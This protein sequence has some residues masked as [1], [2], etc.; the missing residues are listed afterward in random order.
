[1][2]ENQMTTRYARL[3]MSLHWLMLA[4]FVG[5][6]ACIEIKGLLPRGHALK[7][8]FLGGHAL[9]G[10]GIFV[11]VWLRLLGRLA[12]RPAIVPRPPA[13]QT[14]A[15]HLMH[16]A[17]YGLMIIT[18]LLAWLMLNAAGKPVPYFEFGLPSLAAPDPDLARQF[19]HWHEWL[20]SAGYWLIGLHAAAGLFHHYWVRDNTLVR[21]LP[22]RYKG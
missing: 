5:V 14:A 22:K 12:P 15:S 21:M 3:S 9:F 10:I 13:W 19:K 6:Y 7:G 1:M 2:T 8:V 20:G 17:L 18:P 4:L 16:L 11:L